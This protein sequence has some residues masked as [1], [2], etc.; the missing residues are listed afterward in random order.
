MSVERIVMPGAAPRL[1]GVN[2][3][4]TPTETSR[5]VAP[6]IAGRQLV[7]QL[8]HQSV[9]M[10]LIFS[11][12]LISGAAL[13]YLNQ[14]SKESVLQF[15]IADLQRQQIT[16]RMQS[17]NLYAT[18]SSLQ[19][20]Q[21]IETAASTQLH[22]TTPPYSSIVWVHPVIPVVASPPVESSTNTARAQSQPLAW[23]ENAAQFIGSQL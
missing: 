18:A 11:M 20:L 19:S 15:S 13:I 17:S 12:A 16:L 2:S 8:L 23:M 14:A 5:A 21:R 22:M 6:A 3:K 4:N 10:Q 1:P 9:L 7:T